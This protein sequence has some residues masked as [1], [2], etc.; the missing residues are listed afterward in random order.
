[1]KGTLANHSFVRFYRCWSYPGKPYIALY[2]IDSRKQRWRG[3]EFTL[4]QA[5]RKLPSSQR[6]D[7]LHGV[8]AIT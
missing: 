4:A 5:R 1:M 2:S 8:P 3:P 7:R 6:M